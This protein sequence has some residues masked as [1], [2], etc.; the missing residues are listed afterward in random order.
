MIELNELILS[1]LCYCPRQLD[2]IFAIE[3]GQI[4]KA[5]IATAMQK[6]VNEDGALLE[7]RHQVIML[8]LEIVEGCHPFPYAN[9]G[10]RPSTVWFSMMP[11]SPEFTKWCDMD[12]KRIFV[13]P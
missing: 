1:E 5:Q 13:P 3:W 12:G 9:N 10:G 6:G 7:L 2:V 11:Y 4:I 8:M